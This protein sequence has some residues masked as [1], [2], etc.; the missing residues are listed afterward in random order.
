MSAKNSNWTTAIIRNSLIFMLS[1]TLITIGA[2]LIDGASASGAAQFHTVTLVENDSGS[3]LVFASQ[4]SNAPTSITLFVNLS[5]AFSN[6]GYAFIGWNTSPDGSGTSY[7]NGAIYPFAASVALYAIWIREFHT[8]TFFE[9]DNDSDPVYSS[10]S[11]S[12]SSPLTS[13]SSLSPA[14]VDPGKS[15]VDWNTSA[16]GSGTSY[17]DGAVFPFSTSTGLYAIWQPLPTV[18]RKLCRERWDGCHIAFD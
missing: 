10:Q 14:L 12:A 2:P 8:V 6:V 3:D 18:T 1:V 13:L 17:A 15:F 16:N 11:E 7:G 5:P 9:N 4:S